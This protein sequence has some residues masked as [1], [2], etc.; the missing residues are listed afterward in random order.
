MSIWEKLSKRKKS[1]DIPASDQY[2][3]EIVRQEGLDLLDFSGMQLDK[4]LAEACSTLFHFIPE[5][6]GDPRLNIAYYYNQLHELEGRNLKF[7]FHNALIAIYI[8]LHHSQR[9]GYPSTYSE[10]NIRQLC[11]AFNNLLFTYILHENFSSI[12]HGDIELKFVRT[13]NV[14]S[15]SDQFGVTGCPEAINQ[16]QVWENN[17]YIGRIGFNF[18]KENLYDERVNVISIT[19]IQGVPKYRYPQFISH[20]GISPFTLALQTLVHTVPQI[21][22]SHT[23]DFRGLANPARGNQNLYLSEFAAAGIQT[24]VVWRD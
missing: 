2:Y 19:N 3:Y 23:W 5:D 18:H 4:D 17:G 13:A 11:R 20:F 24:Y 8:S 21:D 12:S 1:S 16:L 6:A 15:G 22:S 10:V 14:G 7:Y 9:D